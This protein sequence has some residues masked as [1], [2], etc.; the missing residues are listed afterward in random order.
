MIQKTREH[1]TLRQLTDAKINTYRNV[2]RARQALD[3]FDK[4]A[5]PQ[6]PGEAFRLD[7]WTCLGVQ[8]AADLTGEAVPTV[9]L[10]DA[11]HALKK[12]IPN[13]QEEAKEIDPDDLPHIFILMRKS[14]SKREVTDVRLVDFTNDHVGFSSLASVS[15]GRI[16]LLN[17]FECAQRLN[18]K[19]EKIELEEESAEE[20][21]EIA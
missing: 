11:L 12:K 7:Y 2:A 10:R 21:L 19:L 17:I 9:L 13:L 4:S 16:V 15:G 14:V 3:G 5:I 18:G 8:V 1:F 6:P 20:T